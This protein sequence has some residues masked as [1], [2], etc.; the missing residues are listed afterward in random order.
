VLA[1]LAIRNGG[2]CSPFSSAV[3]LNFRAF[4]TASAYFARKRLSFGL[5]KEDRIAFLT[6]FSTPSLR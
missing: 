1:I 3:C 6:I 2:M 5:V 4:F